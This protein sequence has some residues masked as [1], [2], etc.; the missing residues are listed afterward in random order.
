M[1]EYQQLS[2]EQ[3]E[4]GCWYAG[5]GRNANIGLWDGEDFLVLAQCGKKIG[6]GPGDW[7]TVWGV[8]REPYFEADAGCFQPF[9]RVDMGAVSIPFGERDYAQTMI[10]DN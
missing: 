6:P 8:K 5:R 3:L 4:A 2:R 1:P 10:F 9:K 7:E